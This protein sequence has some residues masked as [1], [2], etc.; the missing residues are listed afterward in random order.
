MTDDA[1]A[2]TEEFHRGLEGIIAA[3]S[4]ITFLDGQRGEMLYR[5]YSAV[6]LGL[7]SNYAEVMYLLWEGELPN[8]KQ[9]TE[10][11][12]TFYPYR[13]I[14]PALIKFMQD[15]PKEAHPM[16]VLRTTVSAMGAMDLAMPSGKET[17]LEMLRLRGVKLVARI[18]T[19]VAAWDRIRKG[20]KPIDPDPSLSRAANFLYMLT[21][22]KPNEMS[23]KALDM[24]LILLAD[25]ELNASTFA[26]RVTYSTEAGMHSSITS[27]IGALKGP[28]HGGANE[29][30]MKM[31][32][33]IGDEKNVPEYI[34]KA[35]AEK[36][37]IM[38]FGHRVYRVEDP[39]SQPL[40]EMVKKLSELKNDMRWYNISLKVEEEVK[41]FKN[42]NTNVDFYSASLLY[43]IGIPID[44][45]TPVF[46]IARVA[47][48][49]AHVFEQAADNR[50]IRPM[51]IYLG[52]ARR[53]FVPIDKRP[54]R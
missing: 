28:L 44:I 50:I 48:W 47:G 49:T 30:A 27:A 24:Y 17:P 43:L 52:P 26:A 15:I 35:I 16:D 9:L 33:E 7:K 22:E 39:R 6:E 46:A 3:E 19:M 40:R 11:K 34:A 53:D 20:L 18:P 51:S 54:K 5:G 2:K 14:P 13:S 31:F 10:F 8:K 12:R 4:R 41:K 38:G 1:S 23:E 42:I 37:K 32:Q 21:G 45:F 25:H 36:K 29:A